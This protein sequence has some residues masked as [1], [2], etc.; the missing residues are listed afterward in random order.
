MTKCE[1]DSLISIITFSMKN[2]YKNRINAI[3]ATFTD[4]CSSRRFKGALHSTL[5]KIKG[6]LAVPFEES[7]T[8]LIQLTRFYNS[9]SDPL[10]Y[11]DCYD[12]D[13]DPSCIQLSFIKCIHKISYKIFLVLRKYIDII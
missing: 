6:Q 2:N 3:Q 12:F 10:S 8:F 11:I 9:Y 4:E 13:D 1:A 7:A 5:I